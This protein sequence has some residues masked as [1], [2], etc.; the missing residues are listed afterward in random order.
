M[1]FVP[2]Y[3]YTTGTVP[4]TILVK[5]LLNTRKQHLVSRYLCASAL[6][7]SLSAITS[8]PFHFS[9]YCLARCRCCCLSTN[10][11]T[12]HMF[13][14]TFF[15]PLILSTLLVSLFLLSISLPFLL[16]LYNEILGPKARILKLCSVGSFSMYRVCA[17]QEGGGGAQKRSCKHRVSGVGEGVEKTVEGTLTV[18]TLTQIH[19]MLKW[20]SIT[21][22]C[23]CMG[24]D[25]WGRKKYIGCACIH[26]G[27]G[28]VG[29]RE[30]MKVYG[31]YIST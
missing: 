7:R 23:P 8:F 31:V 5:I 17:R 9:G 19:K 18:H 3:L 21:H 1:F 26:A 12:G 4:R 10:I 14:R 27:G 13:Y 2:T 22:L 28:G 30:I 24:G 29:V 11:H 25:S 15:S 16:S 20:Y 6:L